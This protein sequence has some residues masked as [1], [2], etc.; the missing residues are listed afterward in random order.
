MTTSVTPLSRQDIRPLTA[1]DIEPAADL[2]HRCW[3]D[4]YRR[5]LP[6]RLLAGRTAAYWQDYLRGRDGR[7]WTSWVGRRPV[8]IATI[9]TNCIDDLWVARR[10]QRRGFGRA[11]LAHTL[12]EL[13]ARGFE[14]AQAG[15]ED[16]NDAAIGF[17]THLGWREIGREPLLGL[18]PGR[19]VEARVF[20][21]SLDGQAAAAR[22][23]C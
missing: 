6:P 11:L 4:A 17:F 22:S 20:S 3:H 16:F 2:L 8:A 14:F 1:R 21:R 12:A 13:R 18:V 7:V 10:Y 5:Q 9:T 19:Q 23:V 15:C